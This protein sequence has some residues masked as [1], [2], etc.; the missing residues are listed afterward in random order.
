MDSA[1]GKVV[2]ETNSSY[3]FSTFNK[4]QPA[5]TP[6]LVK[7]SKRVTSDMEQLLTVI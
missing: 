4:L 2:S 1:A 7:E 6:F 3:C 5:D